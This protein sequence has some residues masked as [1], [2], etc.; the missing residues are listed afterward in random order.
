MTCELLVDRT[1][2]TRLSPS[3]GFHGVHCC[4]PGF[5]ARRRQVNT[6]AEFVGVDVDCDKGTDRTV[7]DDISMIH[8]VVVEAR[9]PMEKK[10]QEPAA[11]SR[12][13]GPIK[14]RERR[15]SCSTCY[16]QGAASFTCIER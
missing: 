13:D 5:C 10:V 6:F 14:H 16:S 9:E 3:V 8:A 2:A 11:S 7:A 15:Y 1:V 4:A 12:P